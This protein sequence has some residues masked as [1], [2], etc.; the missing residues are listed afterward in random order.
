MA[1]VFRRAA[2]RG[3]PPAEAFEEALASG[4]A[5]TGLA[6]ADRKSVV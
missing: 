3:L 4:R 2:L 1:E 5:L 6:L